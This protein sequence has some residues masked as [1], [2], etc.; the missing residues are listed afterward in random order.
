MQAV[1]RN[2]LADPYLM[3]ISSGAGAGAVGAIVLGIGSWHGVEL[4]GLF[5]FLGALAF[6]GAIVLA[7]RWMGKANELGI[8][9]CGMALNAVGSAVVSLM[10]SLFSDTEGIQNITY[11]LMGS[12]Q[13]ATFLQAGI[14]GALVLA[15]TAFFVC[16]GRVL[17]MMLAGEEAAL[18]LGYDINGARQ[19]YILLVAVLVGSIVCV[20][21]MIGFVGLVIPHIVRMVTGSN[22]FRLLPIS[23]VCGAVF[24]AAAD[25]AGRTWLD[26]VEVPIGIIVSLVGA[27]AFVGLLVRQAYRREV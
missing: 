17:N 20:S 7:A 11:W 21:G 26:G 5:A 14:I 27:P 4:V 13:R 8:L 18:T 19:K 22:H 24:L 23:A 3:G 25:L 10:V 16:R 15:G 2:G 12:L 9:L 6:A 1:L